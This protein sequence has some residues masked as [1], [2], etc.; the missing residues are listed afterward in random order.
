[1][2]FTTQNEYYAYCSSVRWATGQCFWSTPAFMKHPTGPSP[3]TLPP[4]P[5]NWLTKNQ[6]ID[7]HVDVDDDSSD[8]EDDFS[9]IYEWI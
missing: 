6:A 7:N 9:W 3:S 2:K 4:P 5:A 1:M 8:D